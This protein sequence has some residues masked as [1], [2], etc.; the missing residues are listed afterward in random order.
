MPALIPGGNFWPGSL[1]LKHFV[2]IRNASGQ[3]L[4]NGH[5]HN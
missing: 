5:R 3:Q 2:V 4:I 1:R